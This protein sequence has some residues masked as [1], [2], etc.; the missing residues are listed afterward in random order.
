MHAHRQ[1]MVNVELT[2][3]EVR[4]AVEC[5]ILSKY[6]FLDEK[7][8]WDLQDAHFHEKNLNSCHQDAEG[9]S[10]ATFFY[11]KNIEVEDAPS[12]RQCVCALVTDAPVTNCQ[13][14]CLK[15]CK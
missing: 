9:W 2:V 13:N 14:N 7:S 15:P 4:Y 8:G 1:D 11:T 12:K 6:P 10:G 3:E 5:A